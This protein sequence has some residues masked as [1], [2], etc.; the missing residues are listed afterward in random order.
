MRELFR[1]LMAAAFR[2]MASS[3]CGGVVG[4]SKN[5]E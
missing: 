2:Q 4:P 1:K 3:V 5:G